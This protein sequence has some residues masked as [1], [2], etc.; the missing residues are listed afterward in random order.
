MEIKSYS[1]H[2]RYLDRMSISLRE[3][4]KALIPP[5][6]SDMENILDVGCADGSM[7]L[8]IKEL[9]KDINIVGIDLCTES[10]DLCRNKGLKVYKTDI[11]DL[12]NHTN[13][14]YDA[15]IF[16]SV[17]HEISSYAET[18][19]FSACHIEKALNSAKEL[20]TENG[21]IILRDGLGTNEMRIVT[22]EF[23]ED[24]DIDTLRKFVEL[25]IYS[26]NN[27]AIDKN[28]ILISEKDFK[29]FCFTYTWGEKSWERESKE[30][31]G[32]L[33]FNE[34]ID[35]VNRCGLN[36]KSVVTSSEK[37]I[38][39]LK[40]KLICDNIENVLAEC[41]ITMVLNKG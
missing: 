31:F 19:K 5:Y 2:D 6:V 35:T 18:D 4:T 30:R 28:T 20:L 36:I 26:G 14:R 15:I 13:E 9:N 22:F 32:I 39:K 33:S 17:L 8:K 27:W 34:W 40:E 37:Y 25:P 3:S 10:V 11:N 24:K 38:E 1:D 29:E 21:I 41:T 23:K 7:M 16:S 12:V